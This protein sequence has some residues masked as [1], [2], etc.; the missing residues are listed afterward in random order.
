MRFGVLYW[1]SS[2]VVVVCA[3]TSPASPETIV[4]SGN[5]SGNW[6]IDGSPY[7]VS[8]GNITI[9]NGESLKIE[10][11]VR[12][13][14]RGRYKF[15]VNGHLNAGG[16]SD[17]SII[18]A[19]SGPDSIPGWRGLRMVGS[20][21]TVF[22]YCRFEGGAAVQGP[23]SDSTGGAAF[24][25]VAGTVVKFNHCTFNK[26][27]AGSNG[28]ALFASPNTTVH[29]NNCEFLRNRANADGGAV[30]LNNAH[31]STFKNCDFSNN[32][33]NKG[34]GAVFNRY[35]NAAFLDC[36]FGANV[37]YSSGGSLVVT[38][39][40]SFRRCIFDGNST[41]I[42]QGGAAYIYDSTTTATFD[43]CII[44]NNQ[45]LLRDGGGVYCW[46]SSPR[47]TDC[48]FIGNYSSDDGGAVHSYRS[49]A[50][51]VFLRCLF[52]NN[53]S[54]DEGGGLIISRYSRATLTDCIIRNNRAS[55]R[56]GG[57]LYIRLLAVP[58]ITNC[59]IE[60]NYSDFEGGGIHIN[61]AEPVFENCSIRGNA[62][63]LP[64]GGLY[65]IGA[66][67]RLSGCS[68]ENNRS[69]VHGGGLALFNSSPEV[70]RCEFRG[71]HADSLGGGAYLQES[72]SHFT[73]CL[74]SGNSA[75]LQGGAAYTDLSYPQFLHC[76]VANNAANAGHSIYSVNSSGDI[77]DCVFANEPSG[78][79]GEG[80]PGGSGFECVSGSWEVRNSL[81]HA[82]G[83]P[84]F[85]GPFT[86][87]FGT[88]S[89]ITAAGDSCDGYG[90]LFMNPEFDGSFQDRYKLQISGELSPAVNAAAPSA[91]T[92][93]LVGQ[94]RN[95]PRTDLPDMGCYE[96]R[97]SGNAG[98]L[99]GVL[100]GSIGPGEYRVF[101]DIVVPAG[102]KLSFEPGVTLEFMGPF[103]ILVYGV[104]ESNGMVSDSVRM[105]ADLQQNILAWRG[106]R[107][108]N[109]TGAHSTLNYTLIKN[110]V[111]APGDTS[112]GA[113]G[114]FSGAAPA[115]TGCRIENCHT[116]GAG[117]GMRIVD[118]SVTLSECLIEN[119]SAASGGAI[120]VGSAQ[121]AT[122][123]AC[124]IRGCYAGSGGAISLEDGAVTLEQTECS[125][126]S[127]TEGGAL[128]L[129]NGTANFASCELRNNDAVQSGGAVYSSG[130]D[131]FADSLLVKLNSAEY[132]AGIFAAGLGGAIGRSRFDGNEAVNEGGGLYL[133]QSEVVLSCCLLAR[134][135]AV[136]GGAVQLI[137]DSSRFE[138]CTVV[139]NMGQIGAAFYLEN[140]ESQI[141][142][143]QVVDNESGY[144]F[145]GSSGALIEYSNVFDNRNGN[146]SFLSGDPLQGPAQIGQNARRNRLGSRCDN[147]YNVWEDPLFVDPDAGDYSLAETSSSQDAG[148][149]DL[150]C[151]DDL[152]FADIGAFYSPHAVNE[153]IPERLAT[154]IM[155]SGELQ[156]RW[157]RSDLHRVCDESMLW[158]Q[159]EMTDS[160]GVWQEIGLIPDTTFVLT[161]PDAHNQ[162]RELRV[163]SRVME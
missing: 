23:G 153:W 20:D 5:V 129:R 26:N 139:E 96:E 157:N 101:G 84:E 85:V 17:D 94:S 61:A 161:L 59:Q 118:G 119:C 27:Y 45:S 151:D 95:T 41:E 98:S 47:F 13:E 4:P 99:W 159:I 65:A 58:I 24:V 114:V 30:F 87:G 150:P 76:T 29:C 42:A 62:S 37:S 143:S 91:T 3:F 128:Y 137:H 40:P 11:G 57:G 50:N 68:I 69:G 133:D 152:T 102:E 14:F 12:V 120:R 97:A 122:L 80:G 21:S 160:V 72:A 149:G 43:S 35:A 63:D 162:A 115:F 70:S 131:I 117:G 28:G 141:S 53:V 163:R 46:E 142:S 155:E 156:L 6:T 7:V 10:A 127:A 16:M 82:L 75:G 31:G 9:P 33:A 121:L 71:N 107:F 100:Q 145:V 2:L 48:Q 83:Y 104:L 44:R 52:E 111:A 64:G 109:N 116:A 86:T 18:F 146:F 140:A 49:G 144:Y 108:L 93:D 32:H 112:G 124:L 110:C 1:L 34:G 8:S 55:G 74:I 22:S 148:S 90:N 134:N 38:G 56:G 132:G 89:T 135:S 125:G 79:N 158:Y 106:I 130:S 19:Y 39:P 81:F 51:P 66:T 126:N 88:L 105:Y 154:S 73:N 103:A 15:I 67:F 36:T 60:D 113:I 147:Y 136:Q 78:T 123:R 92:V 54:S 25:S 77:L 138:R